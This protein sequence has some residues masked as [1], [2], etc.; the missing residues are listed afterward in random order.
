MAGPL[1]A[2]GLAFVLACFALNSIM[3]RWLVAGG[4]LDPALATIVRFLAGAGM[5]ALLLA[6]RGRARDA[7]PGRASLLPA[8][9]LGAYAVLISY[10]Y[11]HIGAAA[12]TFV[13]Y[14]C[15]LA[16][17]T[18][19]G[20]VESGRPSPMALGGGLLALAGVG[21]LALGRVEGTTPLGVLLLAGTGISWGAYSALGR[22][23]P[24]ALAFTSANF[25]ALAAPLAVWLAAVPLAY[26]P[27][28]TPQGLAVAAFMGAV[29]T[30]LS[31]AVWYWALARITRPQA[32][33]YQLAIP[34]LTALLAVALLGEVFSERLLV[35]GGLVLAG[36]AVVARDGRR[37]APAEPA[38]VAAD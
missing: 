9:A 30:A 31:Y 20:A 14:A 3:T 19:V 18:L 25:V 28:V 26:A 36:M 22:R 6:A 8:L 38:P 35:A 7:L 15:V 2:A 13:F 12:G 11:L 37:V 17:L 33:T 29:T 16:T 4:H 1:L 24:D 5:L 34:V 32:G 10:G 23:S 27:L 21:V